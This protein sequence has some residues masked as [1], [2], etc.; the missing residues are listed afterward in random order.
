MKFDRVQKWN[1]LDSTN[2]KSKITY[3]NTYTIDSYVHK[4]IEKYFIYTEKEENEWKTIQ[5]RYFD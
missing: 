2:R 3:T 5:T 4:D 1:T